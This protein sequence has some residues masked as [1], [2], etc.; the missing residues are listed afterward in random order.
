MINKFYYSPKFERNLRNL[1]KETRLE[2]IDELQNFS[3]DPE[4]PHYRIHPLKRELSGWL[5]LTIAPNLLIIFRFT[6]T[7]HSEAL[8]HDIGGHEIYK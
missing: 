6:K 1:N 3:L 5:S 7:D 8:L 4:Q 2:V